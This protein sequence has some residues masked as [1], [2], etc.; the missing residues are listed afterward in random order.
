MDEIHE[1]M[2]VVDGALSQFNE[3][4]RASF[5]DVARAHN[6][7]AGLWDDSMR[8]DYDAAWGPLEEA[9]KD[10]LQ[11][12]GPTCVDGLGQRLAALRRYLHGT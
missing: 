6:A 2:M 1:R 3:R 10:Y 11:R 5:D 9:M 12:I 8:R 4:L 7:L